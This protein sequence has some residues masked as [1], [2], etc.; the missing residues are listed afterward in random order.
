MHN[1]NAAGLIYRLFT[2]QRLAEAAGAEFPLS[3]D[4]YN[5]GAVALG[6]SL[7]TAVNHPDTTLFWC[8]ILGLVALVAVERQ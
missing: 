7:I 2:R 4:D 8:V 3:D 1:N 6:P 5:A